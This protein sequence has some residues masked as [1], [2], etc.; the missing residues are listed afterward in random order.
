M[1]P[2]PKSPFASPW[3]TMGMPPVAIRINPQTTLFVDLF[4][5]SEFFQRMSARAQ[6]TRTTHDDPLRG[7]DRA[8][9]ILQSTEAHGM[10]KYVGIFVKNSLK[11][12]EQLNGF[13]PRRV[14]NL[15]AMPL[16]QAWETKAM[17]AIHEAVDKVYQT[18]LAENFNPN[19]DSRV[20]Q[21]VEN[22]VLDPL[23]LMPLGHIPKAVNLSARGTQVA[24]REINSVI[25]T[26]GAAAEM[27]VTMKPAYATAGNMM[28]KE[29]KALDGIK[30]IVPEL[31]TGLRMGAGETSATNA[32]QKL[33][34]QN[35]PAVNAEVK[36]AGTEVNGSAYNRVVFEQYKTV[37]RQEMGKPH[38]TNPQ[39]QKLVNA[40]YKPGAEVGSGSTAAA[41]RLEK[42]TGEPIH[43]KF[44]T[45]KGGEYIKKL[46]SWLRQNP[47]ASLGD[48]A[49]AENIIKDLKNALE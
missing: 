35:L 22:A 45:Q 9:A 33:V 5:V 46:E 6:E 13:K 15:D 28:A 19:K 7:A 3:Q 41:I 25:K 32:T 10:A 24:I 48:R 17:P 36:I 31:K 20:Q 44:H 12:G 1:K 16:S 26:A 47:T 43:G 21:F 30:T 27:P 4:N 8:I 42:M 38:V 18:N 14:M 23:V 2:S 11:L 37:L 29:I 39:L 40:M 49:A 34:A